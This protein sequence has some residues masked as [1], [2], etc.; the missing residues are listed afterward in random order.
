V[1]DKSKPTTKITRSSMLV[2]EGDR[3][4]PHLLWRLLAA[5]RFTAVGNNYQNDGWDITGDVSG[6]QF[7]GLAFKNSKMHYVKLDRADF[8][9]GSLRGVTIEKASARELRGEGMYMGECR[10]TEVNFTNADLTD[11]A[12]KDNVITDCVFDGVKFSTAQ[13]SISGEIHRSSF[14]GTAP[15]LSGRVSACNFSG[16]PSV[17]VSQQSVLRDCDLSTVPDVFVGPAAKLVNCDLRGAQIHGASKLSMSLSLSN[18]TGA[19]I[20]VDGRPYV[21]GACS[22]LF[23]EAE[24]ICAAAVAV[25]KARLSFYRD[26]ASPSPHIVIS[27][28]LLQQRLAGIDPSDEMSDKTL[29][30]LAAILNAKCGER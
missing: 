23:E 3:P 4:A 2:Y 29:N 14:K 11:A 24:E 26:S 25:G 7:M 6:G 21:S 22:I 16:C 27:E 19:K 30:A 28:W 13:G 5:Q 9:G 8:R 20:V 1:S 12:L 10:L 15:V 17:H 18:L